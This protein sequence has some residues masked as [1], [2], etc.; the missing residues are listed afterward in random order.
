MNLQGKY[1]SSFRNPVIVLGS[2][3]SALSTIRIFGRQGLDVYSIIHE[4]GVTY[5]SKYC[6]KFFINKKTYDPNILKNFLKKIS[7]KFTK[8]PVIFPT[9]D[10]DTLCLATIKKELKDDYQLIVGDKEPVEI[11]INKIKFYKTLQHYGINHPKTYFPKNLKDVK[12]IRKKIKYPIFMK[13]ATTQRFIKYFRGK[14]FI[15]HTPKELIHNYKLIKKHEIKIMLQEIIYGL[16]SES[17]ALEGYYK[18]NNLPTV[19]FARKRLRIFPPEFGNSS[20]CVS[21]PISQL[22]KEKKVINKLMKNIG[23]NGLMGAEFKRDKRDGKL[24]LIEINARAWWFVEVSRRC[25]V[26]IVSSSYLDILGEKTNYVE[27]YKIGLKCIYLFNELRLLGKLLLKHEINPK[28]WFTS[29]FGPRCFVFLAK[30]DLS[31]FLMESKNRF[32]RIPKA[33]KKFSF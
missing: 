16:P 18:S 12:Q 33:L 29:L 9:T 26:D 5:Y 28:Q 19:L 22:Q 7:K 14:G 24:K 1:I 20:L 27:H 30:D 4:K 8:R 10:L 2:G 23:Y 15:A 21:I 31:P 32:L 11:L 25:G 6:K 17:Y 13:P 3:I